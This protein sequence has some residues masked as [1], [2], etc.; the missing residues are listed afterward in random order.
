MMHHADTLIVALAAG[1]LAAATIQAGANSNLR[2]AVSFGTLAVLL[3]V[4]AVREHRAATEAR[5]AA[6]RLARAARVRHHRNVDGQPV[7]RWCCETWWLTRGHSHT[8]TC[9]ADRTRS[10]A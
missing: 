3:A 2:P 7:F 10:A 1:A 5:D 9:P 8:T 4:A 6:V